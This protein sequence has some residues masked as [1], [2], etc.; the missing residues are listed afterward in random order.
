MKTKQ[1]LKKWLLAN[2]EN[3]FGTLY[4]GELD[5][6][7]FD[8]DVY[9]GRMKVKKDLIQGGQTVGGNLVQG[10][11]EVK[12]DLNQCFNKVDGD[13]LQSYQEVNGVIEQYAKVKSSSLQPL[14]SIFED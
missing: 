4:L 14:S 12:G 5:F 13:L 3:D 1:E 8:G 7:D 10:C 6:S 2:C 9:I 11:Q